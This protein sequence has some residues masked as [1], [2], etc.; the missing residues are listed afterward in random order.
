MGGLGRAVG[1]Q[2]RRLEKLVKERKRR[3]KKEN[4]EEISEESSV[5]DEKNSREVSTGESSEATYSDISSSLD[6]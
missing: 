3:E 6:S 2:I 5:T 1:R 4:F